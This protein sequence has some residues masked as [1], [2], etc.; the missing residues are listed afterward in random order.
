MQTTDRLSIPLHD[1]DLSRQISSR[2]CIIL[3]KI[4]CATRVVFMT[5]HKFPA[6]DLYYTDLA[7][8]ITTTRDEP[9]AQDHGLSELWSTVYGTEQ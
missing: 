6:F 3:P 1:P 8:L 9:D 5:Y 4:S 2:S 7:Q